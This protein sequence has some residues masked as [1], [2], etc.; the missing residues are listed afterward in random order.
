[1]ILGL[2][3]VYYFATDGFH[4]AS[5]THK[6]PYNPDW[7]IPPLTEQEKDR[8]TQILNQEFTYLAKGAQCYAFLSEDGNYVLKL[9]KFKHLR[10]SLLV[11]MLPPIEYKKKKI[12]QKKQRLEN[13]FAAHKLAYEVFRDE[14]GLIYIHLNK[15]KDLHDTVTLYDKIGM[16]WMIDL[17]PF[18]FV[19]Q[20]MSIKMR[21]EMDAILSRGDVERAKERIDQIFEMYLT[22]YRR[23]IYD[24]GHGVMH[25][26][27]FVG[28]KAIHFD[29]EKL[30]RDETFKRQE[31]Y[32][33]NLD[34]I[35]IKMQLWIDLNYP[36]HFEELSQTIQQKLATIYAK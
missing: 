18:V 35:A 34:K 11:K 33:E 32:K 4:Q 19:V 16:K 5:I 15:T 14:S 24:W 1:M 3:R 12:A 26:N 27:G 28:E 20:E 22:Q 6:I 13:V 7:D 21:D 10:P 30:R 9:F 36:K 2:S 29:V 25:N 31:V 23:G 8:L 17:D